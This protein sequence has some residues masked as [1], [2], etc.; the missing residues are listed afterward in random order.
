[1]ST[2]LWSPDGR[3]LA[4]EVAGKEALIDLTKPVGE[5][6]PRYLEPPDSRADF[7]A[8]SWSPNGRWLAGARQHRDGSH[9]PGVL[10][11]S[12]EEKKYIWLPNRGDNPLWLHDSRRL[13]YTDGNGLLLYDVRFRS[14]TPILSAPAGS[15]YRSFSLSPDDRGLYLARAVHEGHLW[16]LKLGSLHAGGHAGEVGQRSRSPQVHG[17]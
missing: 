13:L 11:Y 16:L 12:L 14:S 7:I 9:D 2:P 1:V 4:C 8:Y 3:T 5:R 10:L 6:V 17:E 15:T